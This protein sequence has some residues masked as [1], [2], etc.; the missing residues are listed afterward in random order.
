MAFTFREIKIC[1]V[2]LFL[3]FKGN[4]FSQ[5]GNPLQYL[6]S[7]SQASFSNPAFQNK[8]DKLVIGLPLVSGATANYDA[9]FALNY[10]FSERFAYSFDR[11]YNELGEPGDF[12]GAVDIPLIYLS[13]NN[14][15]NT[16]TF[17]LTEKVIS[18]S[19]FDHEVLKFIDQGLLPYYG[20]TEEYGPITFKNQYYR[21]LAFAFST[22][23]NKNLR[24]GFRPKI[25]FGKFYYDIEFSSISVYTDEDANLMYVSP[26]AQAQISGPVK[27]V[28]NLDEGT[29]EIKPNIRPA[30]YLFQ[31][32]NLGAGVDFGVDYKIDERSNFSFAIN[33]LGFTT[34][35]Y[36]N[37]KQ[38]IKGDL[39]YAEEDLYQS[40]QP[41]LPNYLEPKEALRAF[42]DSIPSLSTTLADPE[43]KIESLPIKIN[44]KFKFRLSEKASFGVSDNFTFYKNHTVNYLSGYYSTELGKRF[45][46]AANISLYNLHAIMPGLGAS[47]T[48][49]RA[50]FYLSTNNII[51]LVQPSSA[52]NINLCFGVNFLF[53]TSQ[54]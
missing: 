48:G 14:N 47:Y 49:R 45:E 4:V 52:K 36:R 29:T 50:Q 3:L 12:L 30:D 54:N 28:Y 17:S 33:D 8:T 32:K 15:K 42:T 38:T 34:T 19:N 41:G 1:V 39:Q 24:I 22:E 46:I 11:F 31:M 21:E 16:W 7:V 6:E 9:N 25:L 44:A 18:Q 51:K 26:D 20:K 53:S 10:I 13:L 37:Y 27:I 43:R 5:N 40:W 35:H 2:V 23:I